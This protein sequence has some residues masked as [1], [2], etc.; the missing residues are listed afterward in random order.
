M[1]EQGLLT[2]LAQAVLLEREGVSSAHGGLA[3]RLEQ[4]SQTLK[5]VYSECPSFNEVI[6]ALLS[7]PIQVCPPEACHVH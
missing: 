4:A 2:A 3:Q 7:V 5:Q 6:P 1:Q